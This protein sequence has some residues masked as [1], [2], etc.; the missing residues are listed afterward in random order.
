M[1]KIAALR[2]ECRPK[3]AQALEGLKG[4]LTDDQKKVRAK[5][6]DSGKKPAAVRKPKSV[7][8]CKTPTPLHPPLRPAPATRLWATWPGAVARGPLTSE[9]Q[10]RL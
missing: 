1:T 5:A 8:C 3:I 9:S 6:L 2:D 4:A 7:A 10:R